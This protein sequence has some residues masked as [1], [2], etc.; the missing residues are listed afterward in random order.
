MKV[1]SARDPR[2][3]TAKPANLAAQQSHRTRNP[4]GI[5]LDGFFCALFPAGLLFFAG[6]A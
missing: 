2:Q 1:C 5:V 4:S 6:D 3:M